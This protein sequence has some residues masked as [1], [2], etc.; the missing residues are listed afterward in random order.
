MA[1]QA[2]ILLQDVKVHKVNSS[3]FTFICIIFSR[4]IHSNPHSTTL[5]SPLCNT[6]L[7]AVPSEKGIDSLQAKAQR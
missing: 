4:P 5:S 7:E 3:K 6:S 2:L 1:R